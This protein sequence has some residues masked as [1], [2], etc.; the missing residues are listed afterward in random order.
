MASRSALKRRVP[1]TA[2]LQSR[3]S[4]REWP[5]YLSN[6]KISLLRQTL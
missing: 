1:A 6:E 4:R 2:L 5:S 3:P